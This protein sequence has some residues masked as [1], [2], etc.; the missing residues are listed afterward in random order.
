MNIKGKG[1]AELQQAHCVCDAASRLCRPEEPSGGL[2]VGIKVTKGNRYYYRHRE[3]ILAKKREKRDKEVEEE[4]RAREERREEERLKREEERERK[5]EEKRRVSRERAA[6]K[7]AARATAL[8]IPS[9]AE[10]SALN[11]F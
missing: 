2:E 1:M 3:E 4:R 9:G 11:I 5:K 6:V 7:A 8:G 10:K